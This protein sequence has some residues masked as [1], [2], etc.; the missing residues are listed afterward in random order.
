MHRSLSGGTALLEDEANR[1]AAE[2]LTPLSAMESEITEPVTLQTLRELKGRW[3]V[4][5]RSLINRAY[6]VRAITPRQRKYLFMKMNAEYG[7]RSEPTVFLPER[8]RG[9]QQML[10]MVYAPKGSSV[11]FRSAAR[12]L[13]VP[14]PRLRSILALYVGT[15]EAEG[16]KVLQ[17]PKP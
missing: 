1:F 5:M 6:E 8:P 9:L 7:G 16:S 10:E 14:A 15:S 13:K 11:D 12:D 2:F 3:H 4:S 17:F